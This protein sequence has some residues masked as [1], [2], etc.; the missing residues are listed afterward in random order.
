MS[1]IEQE[2]TPIPNLMQIDLPELITRMIDQDEAAFEA[3]YERTL[4]KVFGLAL[5]ITRRHDL[6]E[7]VVGDTYWQAWHHAGKYDADRAVP[8]AWLLLICRSRALDLLRKQIPD[9]LVNLK[10]QAVEDAES[11]NV[12]LEQ[13][14]TVERDSALYDAIK[15]LTPKQ[16]QLIALAFFKGY[17]HH[18]IADQ[19]DM[20]LG[21]VKSTIKRA[22]A[23]LKSALAYQEYE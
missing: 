2:P 7:E 12:P 23:K 13:L 1:F 4:P 8:M 22:Q 15:Q 3:F 9:A 11:A 16:K 20:P 19:V 10:E 14:L 21:T 6:A 17:S 5:K 18:E